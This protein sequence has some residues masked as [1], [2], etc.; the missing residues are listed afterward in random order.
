MVGT[1]IAITLFA[2]PLVLSGYFNNGWPL[3][4]E[5]IVIPAIVGGI[6]WLCEIFD[7]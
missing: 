7:I 1:S 3:L 5:F 2:T 6:C 4:L